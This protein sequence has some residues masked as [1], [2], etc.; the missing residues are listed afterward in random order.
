[1][2]GR[3]DEK[4]KERLQRKDEM[5]K[6]KDESMKGRMALEFLSIISINIKKTMACFLA[7]K[8]NNK[9]LSKIA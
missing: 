5:A 7:V 3:K 6:R 2:K 8:S 9:H 4:C 1:M